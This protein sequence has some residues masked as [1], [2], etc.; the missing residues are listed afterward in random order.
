MEYVSSQKIGHPLKRPR[1]QSGT[2]PAFSALSGGNM[3]MMHIL[4][5]EGGG[6]GGGKERVSGLDAA[7]RRRFETAFGYDL[8]DVRVHHDS[9]WPEKI[10]AEAYTQGTDIYLAPGRE[11]HLAHETGH[12]IQQMRGIVHANA[13]VDGAPC[14]DSAVLEAQASR[15]GAMAMN[16]TGSPAGEYGGETPEDGLR[17]VALTGG[18][19]QM[20][21]RRGAGYMSLFKT[22]EWKMEARA[23]EERLGI[24]AY[25]DPRSRRAANEGLKNL[26]AILL[27]YYRSKQKV[28]HSR[29]TILRHAFTADE[30]TSAGQIGRDVTV[31][32]ID[33]IVGDEGNGN[34][35]EKM[36]AFFNAA[37]RNSDRNDIRPSITLKYIV[38]NA[39]K[40]FNRR[41]AIAAGVKKESINKDKTDPFA[42]LKTTSRTKRSQS[43]IA[44]L[45]KTAQDYE[46]MGA[47]LSEREMR[48]VQH[49]RDGTNFILFD[50][51]R[52]S[53]DQAGKNQ[54]GKNQADKNEFDFTAK[55]PWESGN[56]CFQVGENTPLGK[57]AGQ[58]RGMPLTA[59]IS[60]TTEK[61]LNSY[62]AVNGTQPLDFRLAL[63]GW[64]L[65][66]GD[67]S[68]YEIMEASHRVDVKGEKE[69]LTDAVSMYECIAPLTEDEVRKH[70]G[71]DGRLP[72][73][74][75]YEDTRVWY[76]LDKAPDSSSPKADEGEGHEENNL[77]DGAYEDD[78]VYIGPS[79]M[80][81]RVA[82]E[83]ADE[84]P[85]RLP[86]AHK[87][88]LAV[89]SRGTHAF[90]NKLG[91]G[92]DIIFRVGAVLSVHGRLSIM[93]GLYGA[94][95][96]QFPRTIRG[97]K[98]ITEAR[99]LLSKHKNGQMQKLKEMCE[100][101][102][103]LHYTKIPSRLE[104]SP[105]PSSI[106]YQFYKPQLDK[107]ANSPEMQL[108]TR[109]NER[110]D[111]PV[112]Q[113]MERYLK[114]LDALVEAS[115]SALDQ[116]INDEWAKK[117]SEEVATDIEMAEEALDKLPPVNCAEKV[118]YRGDWQEKD[119]QE[120]DV[121]TEDGFMSTSECQSEAI[122]FAGKCKAYQNGQSRTPVVFEIHL[123]ENSR[124]RDISNYSVHSREN[125]V[126]FPPGFKYK[127]IRRIEED[128]DDNPTKVKYFVCEEVDEAAGRSA[129]NAT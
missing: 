43:D 7:M 27:K 15:L 114:D 6:A 23:F 18:P 120:G 38:S 1:E 17:R 50:T 56:A 32:D 88:A 93:D 99:G 85:G 20:V 83:K 75:V 77:P 9:D 73:E 62:K 80:A 3:A 63:I 84:A 39:R 26:K 102:D 105:A 65:T 81:D 42:P 109:L 103:I 71:K 100:Q 21:K 116:K 29:K 55:L 126:L 113:L 125:E 79:F 69:D 37:Y 70:A 128:A 59:D 72:H 67:H 129:A 48:Y 22:N 57:D 118:V 122:K 91:R 74:V 25:N 19:I 106:Y 61:M 10:G 119:M 64:M 8:G 36:T 28:K 89:Y 51:N 82:T 24:Y 66:S 97:D 123:K 124:G 2:S 117:I 92:E 98:R 30:E 76:P 107:I 45:G 90:M 96:E 68:L 53:K 40:G 44:A 101:N 54:A 112:Q 110:G 14:N 4:G 31:K 5:L 58:N 13:S 34:L 108:V 111:L 104:K 49:S 41:I 87:M 94:A 121:I 86:W 12:V 78:M 46:E 52:F 60:G 16:G 11:R 33:Q 47:G 95:L 127:I 115:I 35:R